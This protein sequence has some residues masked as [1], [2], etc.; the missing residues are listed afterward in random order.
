MNLGYSSAVG[1]RKEQGVLKIAKD[2]KINQPL[3]INGSDQ[4]IHVSM[5]QV[6]VL[7]I[8]LELTPPPPAGG[9]G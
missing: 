9:G 1:K 6:A 8:R 3:R 2:R 5:F 7:R 4:I